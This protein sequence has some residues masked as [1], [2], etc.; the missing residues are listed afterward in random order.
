MEQSYTNAPQ[1]VQDMGTPPVFSPEQVV[2]GFEKMLRQIYNRTSGAMCLHLVIML[3]VQ[4]ILM[5]IFTVMLTAQGMSSEDAAKQINDPNQILMII[6][7]AVGYLIAHLSAYF[8]G[9]KMTG[10]LKGASKLFRKPKNLTPVINECEGLLKDGRICIGDND[11]LKVHMLNSAMKLNTETDRRKLVKLNP[12]L[13]I[14]GM[15]SLLDALTV[16]QKWYGEIGDQLAN[17]G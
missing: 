2:K 7:L 12:S 8:I 17:R 5:V 1:G 13:H 16:R 9:L 10:R 14:D 3:I 6:M 4:I 15:A 11:L